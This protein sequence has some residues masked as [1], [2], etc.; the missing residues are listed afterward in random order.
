M[1]LAQLMLLLDKFTKTFED[2]TTRKI[3][4]DIIGKKKL[5]LITISKFNRRKNKDF[6][7][8]FESFEQAAETNNWSKKRRIT[9]AMGEND[10]FYAAK[11]KRLLCRV[12]FSRKLLSA[13]VEADDY[14]RQQAA[15]HQASVKIKDDMKNLIEKINKLTINYANMTNSIT[16]LTK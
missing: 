6:I 3:N 16:Q 4:A 14:Y 1:N 13:H 5:N 2:A 7:E 11:F 9:I 12:E 10:N 15:V 8:W